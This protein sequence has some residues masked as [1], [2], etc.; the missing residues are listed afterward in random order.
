MR[1]LHYRMQPLSKKER[2]GS[3][4]MLKTKVL[5]EKSGAQRGFGALVHHQSGRTHC[6]THVYREYIHTRSKLIANTVN[7]LLRTRR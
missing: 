4:L 3:V 6:A 2:K 5:R 7:D 1:W